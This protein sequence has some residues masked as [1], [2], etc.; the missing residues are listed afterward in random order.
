[1]KHLRPGALALVVAWAGAACGGGA[2]TAT[3]TTVPITAAPTT[4]TSV[5][6]TTIPP[7]T[8]T[9]TP[10]PQACQVTGPGG[11]AGGSLAESAWSGLGR[12][13]D[14]LGI[15][16]LFQQGADDAGYRAAIES[17][18]AQGCELI[19]TVGAEMAPAT[20]AA[21]CARPDQWFIMVGA[22]PTAGAGSPWAGPDGQLVCDYDRVLGITF[23]T[24]EAAFV[25]GYLA[26]GMSASHK[27][28]VFGS[29]DTPAVTSLMA[30]FAAGTRHFATASGV[31][32][33]VI[34]W[35]T[36]DPGAALL[37]GDDPEQAGVIVQNLAGAGVD[38]VMT[39]AGGLGRSGA[40]VAAEENMLVVGG[41]DDTY[42]QE[43]EFA[44]VWLT[45][46]TESAE[47]LV[48]D[49]VGRLIQNGTPGPALVADLASGGVGLGPYAAA[50]PEDLARAVDALAAQV[51]AAGGL[52][53]FLQ[54]GE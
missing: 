54:A 3:T 6:T 39:A 22:E 21:A 37:T 44:E 31:A 27:V 36:E 45:S 42:L 11:V 8:T 16:L 17:L 43:D 20:A 52:G 10:V 50:V 49:A 2:V 46:L 33:Q 25:A 12:A 38:V 1:M 28:G 35:D 53:P 15:E 26:A 5:T 4:T 13:R 23:A 7:T 41:V 14:E 29:V 40:A 19:V 32:T 9:T 47:G 34:G 48:F 24:D 30:A 51:A 18:A